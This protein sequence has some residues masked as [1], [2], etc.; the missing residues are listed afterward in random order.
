[1]IEY[2]LIFRIYYYL[3][4]V[5]FILG[6]NEPCYSQQNDYDSGNSEY[7]KLKIKIFNNETASILIEGSE[8]EKVNLQE[9]SDLKKWTNK[10]I[11]K[12]EGGAVLYSPAVTE[13]PANI[14]FYRIVYTDTLDEYG[15]LSSGSDGGNSQNNGQDGIDPT[16]SNNPLDPYY[17]YN[18]IGPISSA[19]DINTDTELSKSLKLHLLDALNEE[20]ND[21]VDLIHLQKIETSSQNMGYLARA[22]YNKKDGDRANVNSYFEMD[23]NL[24]EKLKYLEIVG[25]IDTESTIAN[26]IARLIINKI[27]KE[28]IQLSEITD[29]GYITTLENSYA[30]I[31]LTYTTD[32]KDQQNAYGQILKNKD[33]SYKILK[34]DLKKDNNNTGIEPNQDIP[35]EKELI[36]IDQKSDLGSGI[37]EKV[38]ATLTED[39]SLRVNNIVSIY[40]ITQNN[41]YLY[42]MLVEAQKDNEQLTV[43]VSIVRSNDKTYNIENISI[44]R[45]NT[46]NS[47][48]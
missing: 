28:N 27:G 47:G 4:P 35:T 9:S 32:K 44:I 5:L 3:T 38:T 41:I 24:N 16:M 46:D 7:E 10:A 43:N 48:P 40:Q 33:G 26:Q 12:L 45:S 13:D 14:L 39:Y 22:I 6:I 15:S 20:F 21:N 34:L 30:Y 8:G 17:L 42:D 29:A 31:N 18:K 2:K 1:M 36:L 23:Q 11:L 19:E 25:N 37:I